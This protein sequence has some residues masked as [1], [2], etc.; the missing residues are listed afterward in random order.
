LAS[1][2]SFRPHSKW[3]TAPRRTPREFRGEGRVR[4]ELLGVRTL[5][6]A[7]HG[8]GQDD[9]GRH[10]PLHGQLVKAWTIV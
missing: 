7:H 4:R 8:H 3:L 5:E 9:V 1:S 10:G 6:A 2:H